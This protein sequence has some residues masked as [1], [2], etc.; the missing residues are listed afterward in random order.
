MGVFNTILIAALLAATS[1]GKAIQAKIPGFDNV[2]ISQHMKIAIG[3][4]TFTVSLEDNP[5]TAKLIARLPF[6]IIMEEL[7][8]NEK[9]HFFKESFPQNPSVP[10]TIYEGDLM[11]YGDNCLVLFYKTFKT[12]YSYTRIGHIDNISGLKEALGKGN[13]VVGFSVK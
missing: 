12:T 2:T 6:S 13:V 5:T 11:L 1:L 10:S 9:F 8:G 4:T 7:N 3:A